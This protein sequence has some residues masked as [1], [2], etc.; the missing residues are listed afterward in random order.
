MHF[1]CRS[2]SFLF[3]F[4]E[5]FAQQMHSNRR[6]SIL[7]G[8]TKIKTKHHLFAYL[9]ICLLGPESVILV[10]RKLIY[11]NSRSYLGGRDLGAPQNIAA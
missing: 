11:V 8:S 6:L 3:L 10:F 2:L 5:L 7:E 9:K 4:F 1:F